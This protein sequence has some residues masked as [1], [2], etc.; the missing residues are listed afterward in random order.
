MIR[1]KS[2]IAAAAIVAG[3]AAGAA[4]AQERPKLDLAQAVATAEKSLDARAFDAELDMDRGVL[5]YEI[6]LVKDGRAMEA[7]VDARSGALVRQTRQGVSLPWKDSDLKAAQTAPRSLTDA[8]AMIEAKTKGKV[9]DIGLERRGGRTYYEVALAGAQ[10]RDV[11]VDM[12]SGAI[13]PILD[14]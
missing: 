8:I 6:D 3:A 2:M 5:I 10:D 4:I 9:T 13:T 11:L 12:Q 14:D 7:E 1:T